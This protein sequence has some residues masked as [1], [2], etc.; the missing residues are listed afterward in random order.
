MTLLAYLLTIDGDPADAELLDAVQEVEVD[1]TV[2]AASS[3]RLRIGITQDENGG[4]PLLD[5]DPFPP[6]AAVGIRIQVGSSLPEAV[7][8]G[9]VAAQ[10]VV[11][12][13]EPGA[14]TL[15]VSGMDA[16][17]LMNL[18]EK[19][20]QWPA[21]SDSAIAAAIWA[22]Y[23]VTPMGGTT[24]PVLSDPEGTTIQR[25]T[26]I[27][28]L[29]RLA[30]RNGFECY[31]QPEGLTGLDIGY[32]QAPALEGSPQAVL[33]VATGEETNV[34]GFTVRYEMTRPTSAKVLSLDARTKQQQSAEVSSA[35]ARALGRTAT[36]GRLSPTPLVQAA[37]TALVASA[38]LRT[39][40]QAIVD[41]SSFVVVAEGEVGAGTGILRP[42]GLVNI[43]GAGELYDG[44]YYLTRVRHRLTRTIYTQRI[45]AWRNAVEATGAE[46]YLA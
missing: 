34:S 3:F 10:N 35:A 46:V 37:E 24:S 1:M 43:R 15:E 36:L 9:Y 21:M 41:R 32:F 18:E 38:D 26:D 11:Y 6:L 4:W 12:A 31:V 8:N 45:Q 5:E 22:E 29:R 17:L 39:L 44:S 16:T 42:G 28:F 14:S 19:V 2:D 33:T 25:G 13:D 40:A 23:E 27:R 7:L 20:R 30:Q